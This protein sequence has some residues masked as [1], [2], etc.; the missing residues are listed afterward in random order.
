MKLME[1]FSKHLSKIL[2]LKVLYNCFMIFYRVKL[3][4]VQF[5]C[6]KLRIL[7]KSDVI[8]ELRWLHFYY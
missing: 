3:I 5:N 4:C 8:V 1:I 2:R 6:A 7:K